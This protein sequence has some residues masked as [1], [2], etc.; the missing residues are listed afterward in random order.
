MK[1]EHKHIRQWLLPVPAVLLLTLLVPAGCSDDSGTGSDG[2]SGTGEREVVLRILPETFSA[3]STFSDSLFFAKGNKS[4]RYTELWKARFNASGRV[5]LAVP[6][7]YPSDG[8]RIYLCGF[9]PEGELSDSGEIAYRIDG[10]QDIRVSDE[11]SG[12]LADPFWQESKAFE[13]DHLLTQLRFRLRLDKGMEP[14]SPDSYKLRLLA[15]DSV[16]CDAILSLKDRR[17]SFG[18]NKGR[19]IAC[20]RPEEVPLPLDTAWTELPG[21]VMIQPSVPVFL[22]VAL[23][24]GQG[25]M[26]HYE[27][28]PVVFRE[29]DNRSV[30]GVSYLLSVTLRVQGTVGLSVSV[31]EWLEGSSG[32]GII[33]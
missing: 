12:S 27:Q 31:V 18:G 26:V 9:A 21:A 8:N 10:R 22:A 24:D 11:Q 15:V 29:A 16:Q 14:V 6:A 23:E 30:P 28:L 32:V 25:R 33:Y 7:Y 3:D 17:L 1:I 2:H 13:L 5:R 19:L 4:N 20:G